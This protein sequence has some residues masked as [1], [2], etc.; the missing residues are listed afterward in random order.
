MIKTFGA[1]YSIDS[2]SDAVGLLPTQPKTYLLCA[3]DGL[4][5]ELVQ[6]ADNT[7]K[8]V[9]STDFDNWSSKPS[10]SE[11]DKLVVLDGQVDSR[12]AELEATVQRAS[13]GLSFLL[14]FVNPYLVPEELK[15]DYNDTNAK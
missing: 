14:S 11:D 9:V 15:G 5:Y 6:Q 7:Y 2:L 13:K 3:A 12:L 1:V 10:S 8:P 4:V